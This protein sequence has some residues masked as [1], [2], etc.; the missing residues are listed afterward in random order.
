MQLKT[1]IV[2]LVV[3]SIVYGFLFLLVPA[4]MM[5][6]YGLDLHDGGQMMAHLFGSAL[7]GLAVLNWLGRNVKQG[8]FR[9]ALVASDFVF[10]LVGWFVIIEALIQGVG[11]ALFWLSFSIY[12]FLT[13]GFG[14][15]QFINTASTEARSSQS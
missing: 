5:S 1:M 11:N 15:F 13:I 6:L 14:Y 4:E 12:F 3:L 9:R 10:S 8:E 2:I 7:L